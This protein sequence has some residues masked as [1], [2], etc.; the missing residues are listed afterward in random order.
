MGAMGINNGFP[1]QAAGEGLKKAVWG[2]SDNS[3]GE[4][5]KYANAWRRGLKTFQTYS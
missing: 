3:T 1:L 5:P 2:A 4:K